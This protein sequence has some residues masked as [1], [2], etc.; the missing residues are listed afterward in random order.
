MLDRALLLTSNGTALFEIVGL[1]GHA[2]DKCAVIAGTLSTGRDEVSDRA[3][4]WEYGPVARKLRPD[5]TR[6]TAT[7][8][9]SLFAF[10]SG[11]S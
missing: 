10:G 8:R 11:N 7:L 1:V 6:N 4:T 2:T 5:L 9:I 3:A